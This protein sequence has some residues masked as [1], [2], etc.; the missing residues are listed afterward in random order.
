MEWR[1]LEDRVAAQA[2]E[3]EGADEEEAEDDDEEEG[4]LRRPKVCDSPGARGRRGAAARGG[5]DHDT[6]HMRLS[7]TLTSLS[8]E[9]ST[10][11]AD[12]ALGLAS[13]TNRGLRA[14]APGTFRGNGSAEWAHEA[15]ATKPPARG[16]SGAQATSAAATGASARSRRERSMGRAGQSI[17]V[18]HGARSE[19]GVAV[20]CALPRAQT[21]ASN[22]SR[23]EW[24][25]SFDEDDWKVR[26][27]CL[28]LPPGE[29]GAPYSTLHA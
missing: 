22:T 12:A 20:E 18:R 8:L 1:E 11:L 7:E 5:F 17:Q 19:R 16:A 25:L 28:S 29:D 14:S 15:G 26:K 13:T 3:Q 6:D 23:D 27:R 24:H 4:P 2:P 21:I 9:D 10:W